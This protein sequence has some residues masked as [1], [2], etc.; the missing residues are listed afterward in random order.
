MSLNSKPFSTQT[1]AAEF[2]AKEIKRISD[3]LARAKGLLRLHEVASTLGIYNT[4]HTRAD[5]FKGDIVRASV[6][7][8]HANLEDT[9]RSISA[10]LLPLCDESALNNIP[11]SGSTSTGRP[12]RFFL[13][14]LASHRGKTVN[15]VLQDSVNEYLKNTNYNNTTE[16]A[17]TLQSLGV[18]VSKVRDTF[19]QLDELIT[20]RH[21]IVHRADKIVDDD[22]SER[23]RDIQVDEVE[24]WIDAVLDF[25]AKTLSQLVKEHVG[26]P[27]EEA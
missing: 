9:I 22:G 27:E 15:E 3:N 16:I 8:A 4:E 26:K 5:I 13:G 7:L 12:E 20:R 14:K 6:V 18:D 10:I 2:I 21:Q 1:E 17:S 23:I 19:P 25:E 24:K 11:L